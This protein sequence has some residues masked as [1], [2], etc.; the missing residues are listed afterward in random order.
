MVA[1]VTGAH[2]Y[3]VYN[4]INFMDKKISNNVN[5][6]ATLGKVCANTI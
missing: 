1:M 2:L 4:M 6:L 5:D 3:N